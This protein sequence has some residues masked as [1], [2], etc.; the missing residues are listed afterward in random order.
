[1]DYPEMGLKL[2]SKD[3]DFMHKAKFVVL[4]TLFGDYMWDKVEEILSGKMLEE[5][6]V[7]IEAELRDDE[8]LNYYKATEDVTSIIYGSTTP[9]CTINLLI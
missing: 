9:K 7:E 3:K 6:Q 1:M 2:E 5:K 4:S 8:F